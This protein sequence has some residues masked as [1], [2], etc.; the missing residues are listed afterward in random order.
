M[1][2]QMLWNSKSMLPYCLNRRGK[3]KACRGNKET[4]GKKSI[5]PLNTITRRKMWRAGT[6]TQQIFRFIESAAAPLGGRLIAG[7]IKPQW[8]TDELQ[9][10]TDEKA[11]QK[12]ISTEWSLEFLKREVCSNQTFGVYQG[13]SD[14]IWLSDNM[15]VSGLQVLQMFL[16]WHW[17]PVTI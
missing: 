4:K 14:L 15:I 16:F 8:L 9:H 12:E 7:W 11:V 17:K 3:G 10:W 1:S 13:K 6:V 2:A 5:A